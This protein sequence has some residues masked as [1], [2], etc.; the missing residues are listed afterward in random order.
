[1]KRRIEEKKRKECLMNKIYEEERTGSG[2][3]VKGK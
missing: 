2:I 3:F 1:M